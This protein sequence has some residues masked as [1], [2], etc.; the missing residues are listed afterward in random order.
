MMPRNGLNTESKINACNGASGSPLGAG[1]FS[2]IALNISST[3]RPVLPDASMMSS[4]LPPMSSMIWSLTSS[5]LAAGMSILL[6]TGII[7]RLFSI[8]I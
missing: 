6:S 1:I 2:M 8:A 3:P 7:S 5:G 4:R